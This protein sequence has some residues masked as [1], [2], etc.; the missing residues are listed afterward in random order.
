M[1][2]V[3]YTY[4]LGA[5]YILYTYVASALGTHMT[6]AFYTYD[7]GALYDIRP[8]RFCTYDLGRALYAYDLVA[9]YI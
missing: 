8:R 9:L 5:V 4:D 1:T 2:S 6:S 7:L 3:L